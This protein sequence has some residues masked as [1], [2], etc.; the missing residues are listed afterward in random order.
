MPCR[1]AFSFVYLGKSYFS[2]KCGLDQF[3]MATVC[4]LNRYP[5]RAILALWPHW[6]GISGLVSWEGDV[7]RLPDA[8]R[9]YCLADPGACCEPRSKIKELLTS[10]RTPSIQLP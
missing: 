6:H 8:P 3:L 2:P 9:P 10:C 1:V 7:W 5:F 4:V